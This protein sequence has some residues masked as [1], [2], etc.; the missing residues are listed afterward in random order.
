[1]NTR[2]HGQQYRPRHPQHHLHP[3]ARGVRPMP[4]RDHYIPTHNQYTS[5]PARG[6]N[7]TLRLLTD[8]TGPA[9]PG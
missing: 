8:V 2:G 5:P 4:A 7:Q 6:F 3:A 9:D 1:M